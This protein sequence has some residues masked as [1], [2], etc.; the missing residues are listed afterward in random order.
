MADR[1]EKRIPIMLA[2]AA[3][4]LALAACQPEAQTTPTVEAEPAAP[5]EE[6]ATMAT[7]SADEQAAG[8]RLLFNGQDFTGWHTYNSG[9][10]A[11]PW[12]VADGAIALAGRGGGD[13]VTD[14]EFGPFEL[15]IEW[16]VA[17]GGNSGII[18]LVHEDA[19]IPNTYNT[20]PEMQVLDDAKHADGKIPSHRAGALYDF[21]EPFVAASKP[22]GEWNEARIL[23]TGDRIEHWLN[24][25]K[26]VAYER[27]TQIY[28][29]LVAYSKYKD[30]PGFG[31]LPEGHILL[32]D[33][34]N[35]VHFRSIKI[36][37]F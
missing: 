36:R 23:F 5:T 28:R 21:A 19:E 13:L 16:K 35:T 29:A 22:V 10:P 14:E 8:W 4:S 33:H 20:G 32:Q 31:E 34:G 11:A 24:G 12:S 30:W 6:A 1:I 18:Y 26:V 3:C 27:N 9:A 17:E 2:A 15:S 7:L 37:E 25:W